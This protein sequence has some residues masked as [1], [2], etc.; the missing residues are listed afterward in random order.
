MAEER[1]ITPDQRLRVYISSDPDELPSERAAVRQ[2]IERMRLQPVTGE[3]ARRDAAQSVARSGLA[4][5]HVYLGIF[6]ERAGTVPPGETAFA[7]EDEYDRSSGLPRLLY[8]LHP[9]P[10]RDPRLTALIERIEADEG[11]P[12]YHAFSTVDELVELVENDI[13][14]LLSERFSDGALTDAA[15]VG[16]ARARE[17]AV[18]QQAAGTL[19][20]RGSA[21]RL[22]SPPGTFVGRTHE[23][24]AVADLLRSG[25]ARLVSLIGPGGIGKTR[26]ALEAARA[27]GADFPGGTLFVP[28]A[29]LVDP[30][31]VLPSVAEVLGARRDGD[32]DILDAVAGA[33]SEQRTLLVLDNFEQVVAAA[34]GLV[35]LLDRVRSVV[36]LVTSRHVLNVRPEHQYQ[37]TP[38]GEPDGTR[39]FIERASAINPAIAGNDAYAADIA[40]ICRRLDGLP[41]AIELAAARVRLLPP[42]VLLSKLDERLEVL[43]HGSVDLPERQRTLRATMEWSYDLLAPHEQKVFARLAVFVGGWTID[44]AETVCGRAGEPDMLDTLAELLSSSLVVDGDVDG[45]ETCLSMLSTVR[46]FAAECLAASPD[47][48]ETERRHT[49]WMVALAGGRL[50][51]E[52]R[53][54]HRWLARFDRE[55]GNLRAVVRRALDR[56]DIETVAKLARDSFVPLG[57]RDA[58]AEVVG[59]LDEA[60]ERGAAVA[61]EVR[62]R[63]LV[64]RALTATMYGEYDRA[65]EL[66]AEGS[67]LLPPDS[68]H[69]YDRALAAAA[70]VY[71]NVAEDPA[72]A[73]SVIDQASARMAAVGD[74]LAQTYMEVTAGHVALLCQDLPA[75]EQRCANAVRI[76]LDLGDL[77]MQGRA[78]SLLGLA[79]LAQGDLEGGRRSA[80]AGAA[81]NRHGGQPTSMAYSLDGLAAVA[82]ADGEPAV[83]ARA[84]H[85]A[86]V[87]RRGAGNPASPAFEPLLNDLSSRARRK[88]GDAGFAQAVTEAERWEPIEAL[89]CTLAALTAAVEDSPSD[90]GRSE[91]GP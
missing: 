39:L 32:R 91:E 28:L 45:S 54:H 56:D 67:S 58:E 74:R 75:A 82:L 87:I 49:Q 14:L 77:A 20:M 19:R 76:A 68:A 36:I 69:D 41:L 1:I 47:R 10:D 81:A 73:T 7:L 72:S 88:L 23:I 27:A 83:A 59:W 4:Q 80:L 8:V 15:T 57:H 61:A 11:G 18:V 40:E 89:E 65:S 70:D 25:R 53:D 2:A 48:A 6:G 16:L 78:Q 37:V 63:L 3:H 13:A 79:Q 43:S 55:R 24:E 21:G 30:D 5:C 71:R 84:L 86:A 60:L 33:I 34:D 29:G 12:S 44:A 22:P 17:S 31:L 50:Q 35:D 52:G 9:A 62:G 64:V 51:T 66:L 46:T 42:P 90:P 38:L 85:A 26:L